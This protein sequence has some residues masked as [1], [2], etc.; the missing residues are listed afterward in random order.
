MLVSKELKHLPLLKKYGIKLMP[1][2][3]IDYTLVYK[4]QHARTIKVRKAALSALH[5]KYELLFKK[6]QIYLH[7]TCR[8][9]GL[10]VDSQDYWGMTYKSFLN[11]V[12]G[13][14]LDDP[15]IVKHGIDRWGFKQMLFGYL[16]AANRDIIGRLL[17]DREE[18][19]SINNEENN[20]DEPY[21]KKIYVSSPSVENE[22]FENE[23]TKPFQ[24]AVTRTLEQLTPLQLKIFQSLTLLENNEVKEKEERTSRRKLL[25]ELKLNHKAFNSELETIQTIFKKQLQKT[26]NTDNVNEI[27]EMLS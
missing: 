15:R 7:K 10:G 19:I 11:A 4:A 27:R 12:Y 8:E 6:M 23:K 16:R 9:L 13:M 26:M 3:S 2:C 14:R 17:R 20:D 18:L 24:I 1:N 21:K 25:H 22:F 5:E